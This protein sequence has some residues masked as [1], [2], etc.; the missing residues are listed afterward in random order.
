MSS[1]VEDQYAREDDGGE[2]KRTLIRAI[3]MVAFVLFGAYKAGW[4][5]NLNIFD[6][7]PKITAAT[8]TEFNRDI[9]Q[10]ELSQ[11]SDDVHHFEQSFLTV[12]TMCNAAHEGNVDLK[13]CYQKL[14]G[15]TWNDVNRLADKLNDS[16]TS[17]MARLDLAR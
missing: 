7:S 1:E 4:L 9:E 14:R 17:L 5:D 6:H 8:L 3:P 11:P 12:T 16:S 10:A 13:Q 2:V 15:K